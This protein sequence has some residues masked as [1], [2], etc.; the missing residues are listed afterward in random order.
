MEI[1]A[2]SGKKSSQAELDKQ[3]TNDETQRT[4]LPAWRLFPLLSTFPL[5][6]YK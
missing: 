2:Q 5:S 3:Q 1:Q 4:E 6:F